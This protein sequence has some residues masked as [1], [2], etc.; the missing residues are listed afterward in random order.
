M[1]AIS[2]LILEREWKRVMGLPGSTHFQYSYSLRT[3]KG[4]I[5]DAEL[6]SVNNPVNAVKGPILLTTL[7]CFDMAESFVPDYLHSVLL[8][9]VRQIIGL[10]F[11]SKVPE[12]NVKS[13]NVLKEIDRRLKSVRPPSEIT[14]L[15]RSVIER[16]NWK[17]S[18]TAS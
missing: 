10:W 4:M 16:K 11:D 1:A 8:G 17:R 13:P 3:H 2:V 12:V 5:H 7:Q 14:R 6:A 15:P 9:V 18:Q